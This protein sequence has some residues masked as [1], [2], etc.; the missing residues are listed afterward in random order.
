MLIVILALACGVTIAIDQRGYLNSH[1]ERKLNA[2]MSLFNET[3]PSDT[4]TQQMNEIQSRY[5]CCGNSSYVDWR[6]Y[7]N[8]NPNR[9]FVYLNNAFLLQR[10]QI[11]FNVPDSCCISTRQSPAQSSCGKQMPLEE[12]VYT[13]G[14]L[15]PLK[16]FLRILLIYVYASYLATFCVISSSIVYFL[17]VS[18]A[19]K[20][21]Y[22]LLKPN[23]NVHVNKD[24]EDA[25]A[26]KE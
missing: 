23:F 25:S 3:Q 16:D 14:C 21:D 2:S 17:F 18:L 19:V 20:S 11:A 7:T 4:A 5:K 15:A 26:D 1:V 6:A 24:D 8:V 12:D 9:R 13:R 22:Y 10:G